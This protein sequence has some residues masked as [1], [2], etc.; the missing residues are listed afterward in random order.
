MTAGHKRRLPCPVLPRGH[1]F[2]VLHSSAEAPPTPLRIL[3]VD[4]DATARR[5]LR[6]AIERTP[7]MEVVGE[8]AGGSEALT[9]VA[10]LSPDIVVM[11]AEMPHVDGVT[12][13]L[14]IA[15]RGIDVP[16]V[17]LAIGQDEDL[18]LLA[19][20]SGAAGFLPKS[21]SIDAILRSIAAVAGGE[22]AVSRKLT[23]RILGEFRHLAR[24]ASGMRPVESELTPREWQVLDLLSRDASTLE[25]A[26]RL[27]LSVDT[28]RTHV[29]HIL[30]KLD[31]HTRAEAVAAASRMRTISELPD[32]NEGIGGDG[33][34]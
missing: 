17:M 33:R 18:A 32:E 34:G 3:L 31:A 14:R 12:A 5:A 29:R 13:T 30:R 21:M 16:I 1:R 23:R 28:V 26:Q 6:D 11:D 22:A 9:A 25:I 27:G 10:T 15:E 7:G 24:R 2:A 4:D 8:A 19:I 20:R